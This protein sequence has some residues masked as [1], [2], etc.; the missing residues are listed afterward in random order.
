MNFVLN[1]KRLDKNKSFFVEWNSKKF[2]FNVV[3][4]NGKKLQSANGNIVLK[5]S[6]KLSYSFPYLIK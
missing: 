6:Y 1:F 2:L 4:P 3:I 5:Q